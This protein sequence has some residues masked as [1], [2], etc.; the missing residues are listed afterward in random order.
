[1]QKSME[2]TAV[3]LLTF[4]KGAAVGS[5]GI[6]PGLSGGVMMLAFGFYEAFLETLAHPKAGLKKHWR[7]LLP[8]GLGSVAGFWLTSV[9]LAKIFSL[10]EREATCLFAGLMAGMFPAMF[11]SADQ[12]GKDRSPA[13]WAALIITA[14]LMFGLLELLELGDGV[15]LT[16]NFW[17]FVVTGS[18]WGMTMVIPGMN[19][20]SILIFLGLYLP[21]TEGLGN[22]DMTVVF[23]WLVG[24]LTA[25][26]ALLRVVA[27]FFDRYYRTSR[28]CIIGLVL[29]STIKI[30]PLQYSGAGELFLCIAL[31]II[32]F[33]LAVGLGRLDNKIISR[34]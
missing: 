19:S 11:R 29:A 24:M 33:A 28:Y 5:G 31:G 26:A 8:L 3:W 12:K 25:L 15:N 21:M 23:P 32:G 1:M 4:I 7:I 27:F 13:P 17:W 16:P 6:L 18:L 22:L 14:L 20:S 10:Y 2:K 30:I 34:R 9:F